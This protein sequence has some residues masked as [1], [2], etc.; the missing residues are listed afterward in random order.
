MSPHTL[1]HTF[2]THLLAGGCDLRSLQEMLGHAD[3]A[4]TQIYTHLSAERLRDVYFDAHPAR[5]RSGRAA[6]PIAAPGGLAAAVPRGR[7]DPAGRVKAFVVVLDA[8]GVGALPDAGAYGD[9][10]TNTLGHL[11]SAAGGLSLPTLE[12][13][14]ASA[15]S[16]PLEGVPPASAAGAARPAA[17]DRLRQGLDGR[18]TGSLMGVA[19]ATPLPTFP[20]GFPPE[21]VAIVTGGERPRGHLQPA[22]QRARGDRATSARS[23]C[24]AAALILYTSQDSVLQI[25]AHE[26][27]V[28]PS[29]LYAICARCAPR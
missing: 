24:A 1:R 6:R 19:C 29:E 14:R 9:A 21:I 7:T 10:G 22:L 13:A 26:D 18:A 8:C 11:A 5:R 12:R 17:C 27:V 15:R 16:S 4:T 3:I 28:P 2:A 25:A 23:T 20:D